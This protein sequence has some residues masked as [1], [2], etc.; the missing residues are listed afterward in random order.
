MRKKSP[1][2][3]SEVG[4]VE[5]GRVRTSEWFARS[6]EERPPLSLWGCGLDRDVGS[7]RTRAARAR[8]R[9]KGK[10]RLCLCGDVDLG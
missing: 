10:R 6:G 5:G 3:E 7:A 8:G 1:V 2:S 4:P 9:V